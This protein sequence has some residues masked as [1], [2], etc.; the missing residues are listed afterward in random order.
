M[1]ELSGDFG[2]PTASA[3]EKALELDKTGK[4]RRKR[5]LVLWLALAALALGGTAWGVL[6]LTAKPAAVSYRTEA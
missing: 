3:I 5:R 1:N 2:K 6:T 4:G